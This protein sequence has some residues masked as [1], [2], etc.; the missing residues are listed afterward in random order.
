LTTAPERGARIKG[1]DESDEDLLE[2]L[3]RRESAGV[4]ETCERIMVAVTAEP[5]TDGLMRRAARIAARFKAELDVVH[6]TA[7][8]AT[9]RGDRPSVGRLRELAADLGARWHEIADDDPAG[10]IARFARQH[11]ITQIVIGSSRR[12]RWQQLTGGG[13]NVTRVIREAS[14]LGVDVHVIARDDVPD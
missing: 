4:W 9:V 13:S 11:Q 12:S 1:C 10:A 2:H 5:G 6:V 8:D 7:G 14:A 3:R